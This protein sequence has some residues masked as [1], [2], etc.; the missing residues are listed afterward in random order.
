MS[1]PRDPKKEDEFRAA[2]TKAL[3]NPQA[4]PDFESFVKTNPELAR[5]FKPLALPFAKAAESFSTKDELPASQRVVAIL[6]GLEDPK[7]GRR[8]KTRRRRQGTRKTKHRGKK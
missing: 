8:R 7:G 3:Y 6:E 2:F 1:A 5:Q 4:V